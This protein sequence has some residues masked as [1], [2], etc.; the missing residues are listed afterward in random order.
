MNE[1]ELVEAIL[2][3]DRHAFKSLVDIYQLM[4]I[5]ICHGF[6]HDR[7]KAED[8]AQDI[9]IHIFES[10]NTFR[11]QSKL[12]TWMYRI[13]VNTCINYCKSAKRKIIKI[14]IDSW[15]KHETSA[16]YD[17]PQQKILEEKEEL[18]LLYKAI[19]RLPDKQKTAFILNKYE[20]LSYKEIA[21]IME[22]S[23][24]SVESLIFR[25][26]KNLEKT[27]NLK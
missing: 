11:F 6:V 27:F 2:R 15:K 4:I 5:N 24:S 16:S 14:D 21:E 18:N 13:T 12:S 10:L 22:I 8:I 20:D 3:G 25:A 9:F 26:K 7:G 17:M 1:K 23:L 19:N